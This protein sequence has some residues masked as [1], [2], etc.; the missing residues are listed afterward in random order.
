MS[1]S[2][3]RKVCTTIQLVLQP[4]WIMVYLLLDMVH[5]RAWRSIGL[6][7]TGILIIVITSFEIHFHHAAGESVGVWKD[8]S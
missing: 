7:R 8:T 2:C 4:S 3:T 6:S 1:C 5:M